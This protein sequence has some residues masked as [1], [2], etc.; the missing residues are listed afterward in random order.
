MI[1]CVDECSVVSPLRSIHPNSAPS[2]SEA[3]THF[4][5]SSAPYGSHCPTCSSSSFTS[6]FCITFRPM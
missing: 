3:P 4:S 2:A 5:F 1:I 6:G